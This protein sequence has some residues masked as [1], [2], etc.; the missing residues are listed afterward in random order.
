VLIREVPAVLA[1]GRGLYAIPALV[2]ATI[3]VGAERAGV[4][5]VPGALVAAAVCFTIRMVG[6]R[7][8]IDAPDP[9]GWR[10]RRMME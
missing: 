3:A 2:G 5:P 1:S 9:P 4:P 7:F 10:S 8:G 6:V